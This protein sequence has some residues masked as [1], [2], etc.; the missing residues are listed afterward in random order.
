MPV[1][2]ETLKS[3]RPK[4][5]LSHPPAQRWLCWGFPPDPPAKG[6]LPL[7]KP[8]QG[9]LFFAGM[10][11]DPVRPPRWKRYQKVRKA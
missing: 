3:E 8:R 6:V 9:A 1:V 11:E 2:S 7:W 4:R 5:S 10:T